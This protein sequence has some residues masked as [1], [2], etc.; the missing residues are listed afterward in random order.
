[1][2][3]G[4]VLGVGGGAHGLERVVVLAFGIQDPGGRDLPL[5]V[6]LLG[7]IRVL[8]RAQLLA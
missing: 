8:G 6:D 5:D 4:L 1:M 2:L 7:P 3:L